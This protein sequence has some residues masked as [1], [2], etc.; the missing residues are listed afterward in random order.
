MST[1]GKIPGTSLLLY[2]DATAISYSTS[3]SISIAGAGTF[4]VSNKDSTNWDEKLKARGYSW[5]AS[6]DGMATFDGT[7][8]IDELFE[9]FRTNQTVTVKMSTSDAADRFFSGSAVATSFN[10]DAPDNEP[11]TFSVEF[12]GLGELAFRA[13]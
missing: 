6:C 2:V 3:C 7:L 5:T 12:E 13:T 11:S 1:T 4:S 8:C 9:L 10:M